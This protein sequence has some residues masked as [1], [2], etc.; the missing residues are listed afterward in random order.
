MVL[1]GVLFTT[2]MGEVREVLIII[3]GEIQGM[4][5]RTHDPGH[6]ACSAW[7]LVGTFCRTGQ[8]SGCQA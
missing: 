5:P 6:S 4:R 2:G 7:W 1:K 8:P 3:V